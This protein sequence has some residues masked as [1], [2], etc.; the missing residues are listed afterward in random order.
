[1][2]L[3]PDLRMRRFDRIVYNFP[4]AGFYGKEDSLCLIR[5][6][7]GLVHGF[8]HNARGMLRQNGEIHVSHKTSAPFCDWNLEELASYNSLMLIETVPFKIHD[9]PGYNNKRGDGSRSDEP[10][11]LGE[12]ST[13]KFIHSHGH[14]K[15]FSHTSQR[16]SGHVHGYFDPAAPARDRF[17]EE[18]GLI[19]DWYLNHAIDTFGFPDRWIEHNVHKALH[20]AY[21][22]FVNIASGR[23]MID[24]ICFL[25]EINR[26]SISRIKW[27]EDILVRMH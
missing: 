1:M 24:F 2:K 4:H 22:R 26:L 23:P 12:C 9:Y 6:H 21:D 3:H 10:F 8:F 20:L 17:K 14:K 25:E 18:C 27:L 5:K 11:P 19:F 15:T 13:F 16:T 7:K